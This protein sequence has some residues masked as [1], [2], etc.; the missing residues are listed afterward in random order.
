MATKKLYAVYD[1][2]KP[3]GN[4]TS[5]GAAELLKISRR[6]VS[7]YASAGTR[8]LGR[9]TFEVVGPLKEED[10]LALEWDRV[11]KKLLTAGR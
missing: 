8:A 9:Y 6:L 3:I 7:V 5:D 10:P 11:R 4:Y 2:G 1:N